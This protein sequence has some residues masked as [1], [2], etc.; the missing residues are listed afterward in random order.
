MCIFHIC[1][2][3]LMIFKRK[4]E[5][6]VSSSFPR[7]QRESNYTLYRLISTIGIIMIIGLIV[8]IGTQYVRHKQVEQELAE[9]ESHL[10]QHIQ[11]Q[12][13]AKKEVER[14]QDLNYIEI[15]A[16]KRLGL[17]KPGEIIF[18]IED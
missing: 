6:I 18:Q 10:E 2:V 4:K 1:D 9:L 3:I 11:F 7:Y 13:A 17:V 14:L 8:I 5:N 12:E 15:Q 16:R